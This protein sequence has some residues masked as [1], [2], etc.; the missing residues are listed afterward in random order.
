LGRG[1]CFLDQVESHQ[2]AE[3]YQ[4]AQAPGLDFRTEGSLDLLRG[5]THVGCQGG[6]FE[7]VGARGSLGR[8]AQAPDE[9][10][11][12]LVLV[13]LDVPGERDLSHHHPPDLVAASDERLIGDSQAVAQ[14]CRLMVN[15]SSPS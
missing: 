15:W 7:V 14:S 4:R 13:G 5:S 10:V 2:P 12:C 11:H 6:D 1:H 3:R 8:D 9:V